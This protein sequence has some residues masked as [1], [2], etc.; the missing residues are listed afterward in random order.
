[1]ALLRERWAQARDGLGQV[2]LSGEAG[3]GKSRLVQ[4][5]HEHAQ[6]SR[7]PAWSGAVRPMRSRVLCI[8]SS[9]ICIACCAGARTIPWR[10]NWVCSKRR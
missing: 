5:L 7:I 4:V 9:H 3:I 6:P 2:V 8:P 10:R 1:M